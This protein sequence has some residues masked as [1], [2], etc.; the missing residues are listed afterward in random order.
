MVR[1]MNGRAGAYSGRVRGSGGSPSRLSGAG[2]PRGNIEQLASGSL[3]VRVYAGVDVL[4]GRDFYLKETIPAGPGAVVE[5]RRRLDELV[6]QVAQGRQPKTN[7][8]LQLLIEQHLEVAE[9]THSA[10][11]DRASSLQPVGIDGPGGQFHGR[12]DGLSE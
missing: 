9:R 4:T 3:R 6:R 11:P 5:A 12:P 10:G 2:R 1:G 7:A 8:S